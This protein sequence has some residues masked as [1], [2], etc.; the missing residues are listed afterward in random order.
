MFTLVQFVLALIMLVN[1]DDM[2]DAVML[3]YKFIASGN[4]PEALV[5][6]AA[7]LTA[8]KYEVPTGWDYVGAIISRSGLTKAGVWVGRPLTRSDQ[9][10]SSPVAWPFPHRQGVVIPLPRKTEQVSTQIPALILPTRVGTAISPTWGGV[11]DY[12]LALAKAVES[13]LL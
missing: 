10:L 6:E 12:A 7:F 4:T 13:G 9:W 11:V 8:Q 1:D 2:E 3:E 5:A